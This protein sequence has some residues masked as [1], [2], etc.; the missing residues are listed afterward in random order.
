MSAAVRRL[1]SVDE[2][3]VQALSEVLVASVAGGASVSF[4]HPLAPERAQAFWR[5]VAQGVDAG[6][7]A[8]LVA[9]D[10][11]GA[12][13]STVQLLWKLPENQP[14]RAEVAKLMV[15][16]RTRKRG[17]GAA[18]MSAVEAEARAA[19]KTLLVL[20]TE[21]GGAAE[22]LYERL[23]WRLCGRIPDFA[24]RPHGAWRRRRSSTRTSARGSGNSRRGGR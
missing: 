12:I 13:V 16:P 10:A 20:D 5:G 4:M 11:G 19:R 23:G 7:R 8:L 6:D 24:L 15:H 3:T 17:I 14:H 9:E 18:L 1:R 22:R 2:A 21:T